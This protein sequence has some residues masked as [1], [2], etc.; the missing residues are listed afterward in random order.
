MLAAV[1]LLYEA[2]AEALFCRVCNQPAVSF[3]SHPQGC[4]L[5][6]CAVD[7]H[8]AISLLRRWASGL[9]A[10]SCCLLHRRVCSQLALRPSAQ[11]KSDPR[12]R[13]ALVVQSLILLRETLQALPCLAQALRHAES[14]LLQVRGGRSTPG[15]GRCQPSCAPMAGPARGCTELGGVQSRLTTMSAA[16][17]GHVGLAR[18]DEQ[19]DPFW[20]L[21]AGCAG[22]P[23]PQGLCGPAVHCERNP[24]R[25][26][27]A[28]QPLRSD[29]AGPVR[30]QRSLR[31]QRSRAR[32]RS[33]AARLEP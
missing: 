29:T 2:A 6:A 8:M 21:T 9:H 5:G 3:S 23:P 10:G 33:H 16:A 18:P 20:L 12:T 30:S 1:L 28:V 26:E 7:L 15:L 22:H 25:G 17:W 19:R 13:I 27:H 4:C 32:R 24:G 11:G 14:S 31:T